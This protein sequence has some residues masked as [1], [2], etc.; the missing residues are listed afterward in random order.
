L[1]LFPLLAAGVIVYEL[2]GAFAQAQ[3]YRI[4]SIATEL[5]GIVLLVNLSAVAIFDILLRVVKIRYPD[6]LH[7][8]AL[9]AG[10]LIAI[11]WLMHRAGVNLASIV[12]TSAVVTAVIGLSLQ[13]TLGNIIG[14]LALQVDDSIQEGDWI[15]LEN[16]SQGQVKMI[17]WR[18][19]V[20]ETRDW[21][22]LVVPNSQLLNQVIKVLG[23]RSG[24]STTHRMWVYFNVDFRYA[25]SEVIRCVDASLQAS[26]IPGAASDP[27]PNTICCDLARDTGDSFCR[28]AV[29]YWLTDLERDDP[30]NSAVRERIY[31]ALK[32]AQ[33]PLALPA[34]TLF[35]SEEGKESRARKVQKRQDHALR[36]LQQVELFSSLSDS[37]RSVLA[38]SA[39]HAP[40]ARGEMITKQGASANWLYVLVAGQA[41]VR[42]DRN[43]VNSHVATLSAPSFFGEMALMTGAPR[44]ATVI[45][46]TEVECLRVDREDFSELVKRRP[47]IATEISNILAERRLALDAVVQ[48]L[49]AGRTESIQRESSRILSAIKEMFSLS[50]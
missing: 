4:S 35:L 3:W 15:E 27:K 17:R 41:E 26:S 40:F 21:D 50:D 8:L 36:C 39:K 13:P 6:I 30:T 47:E 23:R 5:L 18:H 1:L 20:I 2:G 22:T 45:A 46:V 12:A 7:D 49:A 24:K 31:A 42:V 9:G 37:E 48:G 34:A 14:G 38:E 28:Y 29:R 33:I 44:E 43:G 11:V 19:T 25:P 32:R 10:Y 16:K